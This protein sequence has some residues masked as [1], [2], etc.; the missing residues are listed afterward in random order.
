MGSRLQ[1][2]DKDN[3]SPRIGLAWSPNSKWSIRA[4]G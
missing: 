4:G 1:N 2:P 3:F